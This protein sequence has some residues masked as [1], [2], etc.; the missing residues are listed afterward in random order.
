MELV[1]SGLFGVQILVNDKWL[2]S[3]APSH[4]YGL[5]GFV[6]I[7]IL[8]AFSVIRKLALSPM[9]ASIAAFVQFG[10]MLSDLFVGQPMG[11]SSI[12]FRNYLLRDS[13]FVSLMVIQ[14]LIVFMVLE[15]AVARL[16]HQ[17]PHWLALLHRS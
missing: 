2:W 11:V 5:L 6:A 16:L 15:M 9:V 10:L 17:H 1:A 8:I 13:S 4:A 7:D 3:A 14:I 12:A